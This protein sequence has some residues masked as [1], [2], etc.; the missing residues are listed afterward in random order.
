MDK[1]IEN[2]INQA[3]AFLNDA[4]EFYPFGAK[5]VVNGDVI[6]VG[7]YSDN[8]TDSQELIRTLEKDA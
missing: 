4:G 3:N 6:P 5:L 2:I 7:V 8:Y 1:L